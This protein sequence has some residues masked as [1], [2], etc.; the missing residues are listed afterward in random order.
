MRSR[1]RGFLM[2]ATLVL[3]GC[4]NKPLSEL[5]I[6]PGDSE[7]TIKSLEREGF[8]CWRQPN[9]VSCMRKRGNPLCPDIDHVRISYPLGK[10]S[11]YTQQR[12]CRQ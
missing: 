9:E 7:G 3:A 10:V 8:S 11:R 2:V 6:A 1:I 4:A 5:V 12:T